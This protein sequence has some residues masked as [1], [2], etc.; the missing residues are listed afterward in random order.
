MRSR[1]V[2]LPVSLTPNVSLL[3][4]YVFVEAPFVADTDNVAPQ[5]LPYITTTDWV[6]PAGCRAPVTN[7]T[8]PAGAV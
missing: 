2:A 5:D 8:I 6:V 3:Q 4:G 1:F 7:H